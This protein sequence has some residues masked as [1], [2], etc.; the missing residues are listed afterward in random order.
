M[1]QTS[2]NDALCSGSGEGS[3]NLGGLIT[4]VLEVCIYLLVVVF[5]VL[6]CFWIFSLIFPGRSNSQENQIHI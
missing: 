6:F 2:S 1:T 3:E 5:I 4:R